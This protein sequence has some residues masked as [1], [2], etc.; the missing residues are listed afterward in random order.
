MALRKPKRKPKRKS[1]RKPKRNSKRKPK[2]KYKRTKKHRRFKRRMN[3]AGSLGKKRKRN[4]SISSLT[5]RMQNLDADFDER[6]PPARHKRGRYSKKKSIK[7][8]TSPISGIS[9]SDTPLQ[10]SPSDRT[11]Q[12]RTKKKIE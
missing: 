6:M 2:R 10:N 12:R 11:P 1:K 7:K 4:N 3:V 8:F 9:L 5:K